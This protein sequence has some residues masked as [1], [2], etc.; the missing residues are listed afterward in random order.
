MELGFVH[1]P[2]AE[3][4]CIDCHNPHTADN[5][6]FLDTAPRIEGKK[7]FIAPVCRSCHE[8]GDPSWYDEFHAS[9]AIL[10]C[11]VC[12]NAHGAGEKFQLTSYVRSVYLRAALM[13]AGE[14]RDSGRLKESAATYR[15]AL[16]I[17]PDDT[18]TI[19]LLA[20]VYAAQG[21][22]PKARERYEEILAGQPEHLEALVGAAEAAGQTDGSGAA[23]PYLNRAM[24]ISPER[25]DLRV[26]VGRIYHERKQYQEALSQFSRA[27]EID[28]GYT[29]ALRQLANVLEAMGRAEEAEETRKS[30]N[31][32]GR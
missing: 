6:F 9:E 31:D 7:K 14:L 3:G 1:T 25:P 5:A 2:V 17:F 4:D 21:D 20:H 15:R 26:K 8:S 27:V 18:S 29:V 24:E 28:P 32:Q 22:W 10:D 13:D 30:L 23:L 12:H 16:S 11:N 19:L